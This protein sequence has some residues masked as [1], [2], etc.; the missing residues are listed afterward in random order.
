MTQAGFSLLE[1][2]V[3]IAILGFIVG[4]VAVAP[5]RR[6]SNADQVQI[7]VRAALS[8]GHTVVNCDSSDGGVRYIAG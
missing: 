3:A 2:I 4:I 1:L 8:T 6:Q 5:L 7:T